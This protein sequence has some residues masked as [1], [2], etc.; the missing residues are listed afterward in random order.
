MHTTTTVTSKEFRLA[1]SR[2]PTG[3]T[4]LTTKALNGTPRGI[5]INSFAS[6]SLVPPLVLVCLHRESR[7]LEQLPGG[8]YIAINILAEH[9]QQLAVKF[10]GDW[11][12]RFTDV[13]W[14]EGHT[15]APVLCDVAATLECRTT[16]LFPAGDHAVIFAEVIAIKH[17]TYDP[18]AFVNSSYARVWSFL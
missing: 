18:L 4:V 12:E 11:A 5:T 16:E 6:V 1:C 2:Y 14:C 7:L 10:S 13:D 17:G 3:V 9:Q 8:T 15:G